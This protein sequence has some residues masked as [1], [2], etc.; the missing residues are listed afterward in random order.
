MILDI[1]N[2]IEDVIFFPASE[3][4][5]IIQNVKTILTTT[6]GEVF[7]DRR[8]GIAGEFLDL[9]I[10]AIK[11]KLTARICDAV[12]KFEPRVKVTDVFYG[13]DNL[14][15]KL[16]ITVRVKVIEKNLRGYV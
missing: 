2:A 10:P 1:T 6:E 12:N 9:P 7:L 11:T 8:F 14:D 3:L 13:G 5:E 15:G 4:E 16:S